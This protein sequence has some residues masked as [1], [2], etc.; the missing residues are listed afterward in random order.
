MMYVFR[1]LAKKRDKGIYDPTK[2]PKA[3]VGVLEAAAK[4]YIREFGS[5]SDRWHTLFTPIDRHEA[6][7]GANYRDFR[8]VGTRPT[9]RPRRRSDARVAMSLAPLFGSLNTENRIGADRET[10]WPRST[11]RT[12]GRCRRHGFFGSFAH[13]QQGRTGAS[14]YVRVAG[15]WF[16]A[17]PGRSWSSSDSPVDIET[18]R[19]ISSLENYWT[20]ER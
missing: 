7:K 13:D 20:D 15:E 17:V 9:T 10:C 3:F 11:V 12:C 19:L 16:M 2:A 18:L 5:R 4:D 14:L 1:A 8:T 6:A